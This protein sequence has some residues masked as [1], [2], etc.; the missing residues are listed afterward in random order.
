MGCPHELRPDMSVTDLAF[1]ILK[2]RGQSL[3][4]KELISE[5]MRVKAMNQENP[6][7][8]I[9]QMH[10][11]INLDSRFLHQGSGEWGLKEWQPKNSKVVK[12]RPEAPA[13]P[14]R[15]RPELRANDDDE[16]GYGYDRE[17]EEDMPIDET[18]ESYETES[19]DYYGDDD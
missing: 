16:E 15:N 3:H 2:N 9:A 6:G 17:D 7:R 13:A 10:T 1:V 5:I 14:S 12:I 18:E 4:F 8:L 19:E 11:E